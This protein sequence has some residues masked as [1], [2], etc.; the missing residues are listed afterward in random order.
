MV[1]NRP[2]S[3]QGFLHA[4]AGTGV[5]MA[6]QSSNYAVD[7]PGISLSNLPL[8]YGKGFI[9]AEVPGVPFGGQEPNGQHARRP[10]QPPQQHHAAQ[11][12]K[13]KK[14]EPRGVYG[15][16][17]A[18]PGYPAGFEPPDP[19]Q[20]AQAQFNFMQFPVRPPYAAPPGYTWVPIPTAH[21]HAAAAPPPAFPPDHARG[22]PWPGPPPTAAEAEQAQKDRGSKVFVGGL[23]PSSTAETLTNYFSWFGVVSDA[24]VVGGNQGR[25]NRG[26]GF[27]EFRDG[28]PP[29]L[30]GRDHIIDQRRCGVKMYDY[31]PQL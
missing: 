22:M 3:E 20:L 12:R 10:Q 23:P 7:Q 8:N 14:P 9:S 31:T 1:M 11:Q 16:Y 4:Q 15:G 25:K 21:A 24:V 17:D 18:L 27:V 19:A 29:G 28:I 26:F 30:L 13:Q 5:D 2:F 6:P